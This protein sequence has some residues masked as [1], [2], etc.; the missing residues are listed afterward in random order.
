MSASSRS[1]W[2][3]DRPAQTG[4]LPLTATQA[5]VEP[6]DGDASDDQARTEQVQRVASAEGELQADP[7][8]RD[9][10]ESAGEEEHVVVVVSGRGAFRS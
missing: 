3:T 1:C 10:V 5:R 7:D 4:D 9:D 8:E 2:N 6:E